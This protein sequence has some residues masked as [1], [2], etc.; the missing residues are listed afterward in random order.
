MQ[1]SSLFFRWWDPAEVAESVVVRLARSL[2][3]GGD[4][5][6]CQFRPGYIQTRSLASVD[7]L[8]QQ[9][10]ISPSHYLRVVTVPRQF[11]GRKA[12]VY[13]TTRP[14]AAEKVA[15]NV[16]VGMPADPA[17]MPA[18]VAV[19]YP[20]PLPVVVGASFVS[21]DGTV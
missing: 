7:L 4:S 16:P 9:R 15:V 8:D 1:R 21:C 14:A 13:M 19:M 18:I 5:T 17:L 10:S 2:G 12:T 20:L 3:G 6:R 11:T